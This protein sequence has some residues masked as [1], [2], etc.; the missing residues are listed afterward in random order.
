MI[1]AVP[2]KDQQLDDHYF[3]S[4]PERVYAFMLDFEMEAHKLGITISTRHN[5]VAPNQFEC[6][7]VHTD[8][9]VAI[10]QNQ[11]LMDLMDRVARRH[12][13]RVLLHEKPYKGVNGSGKHNN[14]SLQTDTGKNL[15]SPGH[16]PKT[17]LQ[18][19]T[20]FINTIKAVHDHADL[21]RAAVASA[22]NDHRLGAHEAPPAIISAFIGSTLTGVLNELEKRVHKGLDDYDKDDIK[23]EIHKRIPD[24]LL[25][26]TDR[27][28]TSPFAFTGNKFEIRAVGA[29]A[30]CS[31]TMI[32]LNTMVGNQLNAFAEAVKKMVKTEHIK[33]DAAILRILREYVI[34]SKNIRFE[35]DNYSEAWQKEAQSRGLKMINNTPEALDLYRTRAAEMLFTKTGIYTKRELKAFFEVLLHNYESIIDIEARTLHTMIQTQVLPVVLEYQNNIMQHI[36]NALAIGLSKNSLGMQY[37]LVKKLNGHINK[38][39]K[40]LENLEVARTKALNYKLLRQRAKAYRT[41]V[42]PLF[43]EIRYYADTLETLTDNRLWPL[44]KYHELLFIR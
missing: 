40:L 17:N 43:A 18:F 8:V 32:V 29:S 10:D 35:G 12:Y 36:K 41:Q 4:I 9:N 14:W 31:A 7:A 33:K 27:N 13:F 20:F 44:P 22:G 2:P 24:L 30:N 15:L 28:R 11:L 5:E 42:R 34:A 1:G 23:L 25:D 16:T 37:T 26:N 21:L 6:A 19:L 38:L 39:Q 3:G